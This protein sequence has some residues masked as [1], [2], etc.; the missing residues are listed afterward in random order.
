MYEFNFTQQ[1]FNQFNSD[2]FY[3]RSLVSTGQLMFDNQKAKKPNN[4]VEAL[5]SLCGSNFTDPMPPAAGQTYD[6]DRIIGW[7]RNNRYHFLNR[8]RIY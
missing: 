2:E 7:V 1:I 6:V 8:L 4:M 5:S 3:N